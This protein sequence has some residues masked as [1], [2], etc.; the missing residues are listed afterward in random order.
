MFIV[1]RSAPRARPG[2]SK[3][4]CESACGAG[5]GRQSGAARRCSPPP[6]RYWRG[7]C[8]IIGSLIRL[9]LA[10]PCPSSRGWPR[11]L[12]GAPQPVSAL[13][14]A[15]SSSSWQPSALGIYRLPPPCLCPSRPAAPCQSIRALAS[16]A[17]PSSP[18][19]RSGS[20]ITLRSSASL[21]VL[22]HLVVFQALCCGHCCRHYTAQPSPSAART[23]VLRWCGLALGLM[24]RSSATTAA[25]RC[26][27]SD[28][29]LA[30]C[31]GSWPCRAGAS[32][33]RIDVVFLAPLL[34]SCVSHPSSDLVLPR[35]V[36]KAPLASR[37]RGPASTSACALVI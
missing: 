36:L 18:L 29:Y 28:S 27:A 14:S 8:L 21:D 6:A 35:R 34:V 7:A 5:V 26:K 20:S 15:P 2:E 19:L 11:P 22:Q 1:V 33:W 25:S 13:A 31:V 30:S 32:S 10:L 37:R 12:R 17:A 23:L 3:G 16:L 24:R 4:G 9:P